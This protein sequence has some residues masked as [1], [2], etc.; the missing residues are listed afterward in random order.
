VQALAAFPDVVLLNRNIR[1]TTDWA[2]RS[3]PAVDVMDAIQTLRLRPGKRSTRKQSSTL[4]HTESQGDQSAIEISLQS[5]HVFPSYNPSLSGR[6]SRGPIRTSYA[7][8]GFGSL[9]GTVANLAACSRVTGLLDQRVGMGSK[10]VSPGLV[11]DNSFSDFGF[12]N[13]MAARSV[14]TQADRP[15][16]HNPTTV[17]ASLRQ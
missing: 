8:N 15:L 9:F 10:L 3:S 4:R 12:H 6:S 1:W 7:G 2:T 13:S 11:R 17:S 14:P 16:V 5:Q